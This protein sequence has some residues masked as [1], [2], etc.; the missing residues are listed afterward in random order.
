MLIGSAKNLEMHR[1]YPVFITGEQRNS[2]NSIKSQLMMKLINRESQVSRNSLPQMGASSKLRPVSWSFFD[3]EKKKLISPAMGKV[4]SWCSSVCCLWEHLSTY[5]HIWACASAHKHIY[6]HISSL[7]ARIC[8]ACAL[9]LIWACNDSRIPTS[10]R[11][12]SFRNQPIWR[13]CPQTQRD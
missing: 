4:R 5:T 9:H 3:S 7:S 10:A 8:H 12:T 11:G 1:E 2:A 6:T 13:W